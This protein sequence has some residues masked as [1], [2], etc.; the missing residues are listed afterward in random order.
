MNPEDFWKPF[1]VQIDSFDNLL[2][3]INEVMG[4]AEKQNIQFAWRG[5]V[6]AREA[7]SFSDIPLAHEFVY[8]YQGQCQQSP[9]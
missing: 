4:K 6:D 9:C 8:L 5:L 3:I 1:E 2:K 7:L